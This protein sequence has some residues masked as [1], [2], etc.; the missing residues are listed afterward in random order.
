MTAANEFGDPLNATSYA[1]C[2][3]DAIGGVRSLVISAQ[4]PA[5]GLCAGRACWKAIGDKGFRY[6]DP[7]LTPD[8]VKKLQLR[9]GAAGRAK[10]SASLEGPALTLPF[11]TNGKVL[12]QSPDVI[13]QLVNDAP[14]GVCWEVRHSAP[15]KRNTLELFKDT[16]D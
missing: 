13:V 8:G 1:L 16:G 10:I 15:A 3:Y 7:V 9:A 12:Q 14:A 11:Q 2:V 5:G 4:A 6:V